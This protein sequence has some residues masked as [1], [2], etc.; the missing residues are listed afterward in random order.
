MSSS[1]GLQVASMSRAAS[2]IHNKTKKLS[3]GSAKQSSCH[4]RIVHTCRAWSENTA[5]ILGRRSMRANGSC[6]G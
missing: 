2:V 1:C 6:C 5:V 3:R 4:Q